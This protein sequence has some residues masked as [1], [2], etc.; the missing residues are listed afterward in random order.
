MIGS[1]LDRSPNVE[2]EPELREAHPNDGP[3]VK[4]FETMESKRLVNNEALDRSQP[5]Q[6][7]DD[8]PTVL[9][10]SIDVKGGKRNPD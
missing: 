7:I 5:L 4:E 6:P 3:L 10:G 9:V 2:R 8:Q 1:Q